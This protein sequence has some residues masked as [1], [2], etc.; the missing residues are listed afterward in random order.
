V[1]AWLPDWLGRPLYSERMAKVHVWA[2]FVLATLN[3]IF[4]LIQG[5]EGAPRRFAVL[6]AQYDGLTNAA[7][8]VVVLLGLFQ[9]LFFWNIVQTIRGKVV[10]ERPLRERMPV[11]V[12]EGVLVVAVLGL[13]AA[14]FATGWITGHYTTQSQTKTVTVGS[15]AATTTATTPSADEG[16]AVFASANCGSCHT[17][18]A[19]GTNGTVG[20]N[21]DQR[22]PT[23]QLVVRRVTNGLRAMPSFKGQLST[24]QIEAVAEYV[25]AST[26]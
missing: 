5:L 12:A 15:G 17:L 22:K 9:L 19:A 23:K 3:S 16:K 24:D 14:S 21:L 7:V 8:P 1:Y 26:R 20:P 18:A 25:A 11:V 13:L 4:W 6:P 2:T 10:E